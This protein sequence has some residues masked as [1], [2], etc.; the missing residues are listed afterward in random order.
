MKCHEENQGRG[1]NKLSQFGEGD[2]S[3]VKVKFNSDLC[4]SSWCSQHFLGNILF[5]A[6]D[7]AAHYSSICCK[8]TQ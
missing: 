7:S 8:R 3:A 5:V 1:M 6:F 4:V 2:H